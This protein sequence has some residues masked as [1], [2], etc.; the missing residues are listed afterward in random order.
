MTELSRIHARKRISLEKRLRPLR[1]CDS[2]KKPAKEI[3][4]YSTRK[5]GLDRT[6]ANPQNDG[7]LR[8]EGEFRQT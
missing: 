1:R 3:M 5:K 8:H 2:F 4:R 7:Q 6:A